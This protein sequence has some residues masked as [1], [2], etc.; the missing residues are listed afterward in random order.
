MT[1]FTLE[2]EVHLRYFADNTS[3][4]LPK[5]SKGLRWLVVEYFYIVV[6]LL[7]LKYCK[8]SW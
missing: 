8:S 4:L 7:L 5:Y 3:V 6:L 1:T 2:F